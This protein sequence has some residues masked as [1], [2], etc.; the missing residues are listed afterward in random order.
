[1]TEACCPA[2][3]EIGGGDGVLATNQYWCS[4]P[5]CPVVSFKGGDR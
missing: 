2:C 5:D 4:N 3:E 1:M